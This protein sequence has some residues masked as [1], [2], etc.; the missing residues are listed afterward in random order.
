MS[1]IF[2]VGIHGEA[3]VRR[4]QVLNLNLII[5]LVVFT[6]PPQFYYPPLTL[7]ANLRNHQQ[8]MLAV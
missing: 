2:L 4:A 1:Y 6:V 7:P 8:Q 3:G 5:L